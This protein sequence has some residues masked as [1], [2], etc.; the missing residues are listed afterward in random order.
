MPHSLQYNRKASLAG[1]PVRLS[2]LTSQRDKSSGYQHV[3]TPPTASQGLMFVFGSEGTQS[4]HMRNVAFDLDLLF[5]DKR[6]VYRGR[7]SMPCSGS[8]KK[9]RYTTTDD[10]KYAVEVAPG[11]YSDAKIGVSRLRL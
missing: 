2:V 5:F 11:A 4:F 9:S 7:F 8:D 6:G 3:K 1:K 10:C